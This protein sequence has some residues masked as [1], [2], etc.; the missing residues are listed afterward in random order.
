MRLKPFR[1]INE[2]VHYQCNKCKKW[3]PKDDFYK[4]NRRSIGITSSCKWCHNKTSILTRDI[5]R[6]KE[7]DKI[8]RGIRRIQEKSKYT[9]KNLDNEI[10]KPIPF[11][12]DSYYV[13]NLG[14]VKSLKWGKEILLKLNKNE[15]GY[16]QVCIHYTNG[17]KTRKVHRLVAQSFISNPNE[18]SEIN[19]KDEDKTNSKVSNLEWCN[20]VYNMNYGTWKER[21]RIKSNPYVFAYEFKLVD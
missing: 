6:A 3:L 16:L 4:D 14:R 5:N 1:F 19:H 10:W 18:Y 12:N 2:E 21:R 11:T 17:S 13:S 20:R 8:S 15:K 7:R 9:V